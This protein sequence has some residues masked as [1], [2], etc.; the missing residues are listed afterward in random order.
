MKKTVTLL[1]AVLLCVSLALAMSACDE[2]VETPT[3]D[4]NGGNAEAPTADGSA[5]DAP[6]TNAPSTST[7]APE[8]ESATEAETDPAPT[9]PSLPA[10]PAV[11]GG[12]QNALVIR[13]R[14]NSDGTVT[15][16]VSVD[17]NV[18]FAGLTGDLNY[19]PSVLSLVSSATALNGMVVNTA[20]SGKVS[21]SYAAISNLTTAQDLF[22]VTFSY[23]GT[24]NTSLSFSIDA[25]DFCNAS[26]E[27][28]SYSV[29]G[30][31]LTIE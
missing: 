18:S 17:G 28:V 27:N 8:T 7:D 6:A 29:F 3:T 15:A 19:D 30:T 13:Y 21:F 20:N 5:T 4:A 23:S 31:T 25:D 11:P 26:F 10:D 16:T 22:S 12:T 2:Y 9:G 24:V 1:L 14:A